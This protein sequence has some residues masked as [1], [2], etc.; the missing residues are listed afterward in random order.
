MIWS[1]YCQ[2]R[3]PAIKQQQQSTTRTIA[4][5]S[6]TLVLFLG[7]SGRGSGLKGGGGGGTAGTSGGISWFMFFSSCSDESLC[8]FR[9]ET[10]DRR[11]CARF[12]STILLLQ[13]EMADQRSCRDRATPAARQP[14]KQKNDHDEHDDGD[15]NR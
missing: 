10:V 1:P 5:I 11:D 3:P 4:T 7:S 2:S 8:S 14:P 6:Q 12:H 15:R 9:A 13:I